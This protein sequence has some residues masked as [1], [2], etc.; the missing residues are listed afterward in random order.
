M[1]AL[2]MV[3]ATQTLPHHPSENG[4]SLICLPWNFSQKPDCGDTSSELKCK[5]HAAVRAE[6]GNNITF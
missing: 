4:I 1:V 3:S 5:S 6:K 2:H